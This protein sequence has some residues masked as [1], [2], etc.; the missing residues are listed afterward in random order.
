MLKEK[1][2]KVPKLKLPINGQ[3]WIYKRPQCSASGKVEKKRFCL[4]SQDSVIWK[5]TGFDDADF[6]KQNKQ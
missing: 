4:F 1:K 5:M 3:K 2:A 6:F